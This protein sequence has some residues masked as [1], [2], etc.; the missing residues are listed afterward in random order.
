MTNQDGPSEQDR[1]GAGIGRRVHHALL[2]DQISLVSI[3]VWSG[4]V[5]GRVVR[6]DKHRWKVERCFAWT[7]QF[8]RLVARHEHRLEDFRPFVQFGPMQRV[9]RCHG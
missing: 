8:R 9:S 7:R 1:D 4:H 3:A 2:D 6:R 5:N